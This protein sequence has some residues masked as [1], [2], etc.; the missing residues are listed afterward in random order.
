MRLKERRVY[1]AGTGRRY[2]VTIVCV[3]HRFMGKL[4]LG[5]R[6]SPS[7]VGHREC[8]GIMERWIRTLKEECLYLNVFETLEEARQV[9]SEFSDRYNYGW[10]I[11]RDASG[12]G[13][14]SVEP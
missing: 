6:P 9:I 7:Y 11:K 5:I 8:N 1:D 4:R 12:P 14:W 3:A 10:L 13:P 2:P